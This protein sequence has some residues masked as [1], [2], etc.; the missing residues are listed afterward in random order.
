[1][2]E[3]SRWTADHQLILTYAFAGPE[4][5]M[6]VA[7]SLDDRNRAERLLRRIDRDAA[8]EV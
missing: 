2:D 3:F 6:M 4:G 7:D 1:M 5:M 8:N